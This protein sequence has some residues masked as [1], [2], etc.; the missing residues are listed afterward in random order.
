M[1][2]LRPV[3]LLALSYAAALLLGFLLYI[4]L[5]RSPM[6]TGMPVLFYRGLALAVV[7]AL[8]LCAIGIGLR[9]RL[10]IDSAT[11]AGAVAISLSFNICFLV[12]FP[13][14]FDRSISMFLLAR[15]E[16]QDGQL[17]SQGLK[18]VF[19]MEYLDEMQQ[20]DRR[21]AEQSLSGN[22][23]VTQG[24]ISITP[25]GRQLLAGARTVG[26]WF[27]TDPRFITAAPAPAF[28]SRR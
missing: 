25:Q 4:S 5:I 26:A 16:R 10:R 3:A 24:R 20:I 14:T 6:L 19:A 23:R 11:L 12:I 27:D 9:R 2:L 18:Q 22:I 8:L 21:I 15:I 17:D 1:T 7:A 28:D 13:V